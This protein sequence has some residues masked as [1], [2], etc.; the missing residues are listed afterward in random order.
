MLC[1]ISLLLAGLLIAPMLHAQVK[2]EVL[3][4][5]KQFLVK[6]SLEIG[7]RV[8][9]HSGQ[10]LN[11]TKGDWLSIS[12]MDDN[13][14]AVKQIGSM[15]V[16]ED[17]SIE[18]SYMATQW[19]DIG[20]TFDFKENARYSIRARVDLFDWSRDFYADAKHFEMI[21]GASLWE[22]KFGVPVKA[23]GELPEIRNYILQQALYL[24]EPQLYLRITDDSGKTVHAVERLAPIIQV[25]RPEA[26]VDTLSRLHVFTQ[27][28]MKDF[29]HI[30]IDPDGT[31]QQ[32]DTY[33][34]EGYRPTLKVSPSG[35]VY[36]AG[37]IRQLRRTDIPTP[38]I[39]LAAATA[40]TNMS[41]ETQQIN[42]ETGLPE[43]APT[44]PPSDPFKQAHEELEKMSINGN[45]PDSETISEQ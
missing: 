13:N 44:A 17:V 29:A 8:V 35:G 41:L 32:R 9:N 18:S 25:S 15:P 11:L 37:G 43:P 34:I 40:S 12:V 39:F 20:Q 10:T 1:R 2:V 6:E 19:L 4:K 14:F 7:V 27:I 38:P 23:P 31:I 24:E 16:A 5:Q 36:V 30:I 3:L 33:M 45:E 22:Q 28:S 26:Q 21:R 42:P